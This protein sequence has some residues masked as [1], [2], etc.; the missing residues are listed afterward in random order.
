M[1]PAS[2]WDKFREKGSRSKAKQGDECSDDEDDSGDEGP[3][4]L[5]NNLSDEDFDDI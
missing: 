4:L 3:S 2:F 5:N 1:Q